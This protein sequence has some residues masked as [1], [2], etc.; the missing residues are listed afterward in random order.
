MKKLMFALVIVLMI[1][2]NALGENCRDG[3]DNDG[4]SLVDCEDRDDCDFYGCDD[5]L[6]CTVDEECLSG[7]CHWGLTRRDCDDGISCTDDLCDEGINA[8]V[9]VPNDGNCTDDGLYCNGEEL[10]DPV[11]DCYSTGNPCPAS[12][13]EGTGCIGEI[14][15]YVDIDPYSC[16][17]SVNIE[18]AGDKIQV[19]I[20]G[21]DELDVMDIDL[22]SIMIQ[23]EGVEGGVAPVLNDYMDRSTPFEGDF[24]SC[25]DCDKDDKPFSDADGTPDE[26]DKERVCGSDGY[27]DMS[28]YFLIIEL[29]DVL[30]LHEVNAMTV[31]LTLTATLKDGTE[32][33]GMDCV[34]FTAP[35]Q[36]GNNT[37]DPGEDCEPPGGCCSVNCTFEPEGT[38]CSDGVFCNGQETC[39]G[40]GMCN[41]GIPVNCDDEISCT[42]DF[43]D[44]DT[45]TCV[46]IPDDTACPDR[47]GLFCNGGEICDPERDCR[48]DRS[49]PSCPCGTACNEETDTCDPVSLIYFRSDFL[50]EG[51]SG[52]WDGSSLK[53]FEDVWTLSLGETVDVEIWLSDLTVAL[54]TSGFFITYDPTLVNITNVVPN[55]TNNGGQWEG[56]TG[57]SFEVEPGQWLLALVKFGC[58]DP[59]EGQDVLF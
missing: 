40:S 53:S 58:V 54:L 31:A 42:D 56:T 59:D 48:P 22:G 36:C 21:T 13:N 11:N 24:C 7:E 8:C 20:M 29:V 39:D 9:N 35:W 33:A 34:S 25:L 6:Y 55:D 4:D 43:C 19:T 14:M 52:G 50:E 10:C 38:L 1:T 47:D 46:N 28:V 30:K 44:P 32:I 18:S 3:V 23:R 26:E 49:H 27:E 37:I 16:P 5:G 41:P 57:N 17:N 45:D 51:N 2:S 15:V 12:C